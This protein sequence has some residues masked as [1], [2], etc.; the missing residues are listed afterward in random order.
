MSRRKKADLMKKKAE[1]K[2]E[3]KFK[4]V[5]ISED[6]TRLRNKLFWY[7]KQKCQHTFIRDGSVICKTDGR[8]ITLNTP[9][10]L[11]LIGCENVDYK[12]F[13]IDV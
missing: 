3:E 13:G 8:Y 5:Y 2:N 11:F 4:D 7:A 10:D 12:D 1:L 9:D 6:L